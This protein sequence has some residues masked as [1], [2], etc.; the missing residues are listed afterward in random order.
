MKIA[1][2][3]LRAE[4]FFIDNS[5]LVLT[6]VGVMGTVTTALLAGK[7]AYTSGILIYETEIV[8]GELSGKRKFEMCWKLF[9][10]AVGTGAVTIAAIVGA[11]HIST[12]R[13]A[14]LAAA[15]SLSERAFTEYR[16]KIVETLGTKSERAVRDDI[17][18][19]RVKRTSEAAREIIVTGTEVICLDLMG[20]RYFNSSYAALKKA[21]NDL[22]FQL[23]HNGYATLSDFYASLGLKTTA[24]SDE[25]GWNSDTKL[26]LRIT[27][28]MTLDDRPCLAFEIQTHP[29]RD[30]YKFH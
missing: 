24:Y 19:D 7:A 11:N 5:P 1:T 15:Y 9:V 20:D 3:A 4:K 28:A 14:G 6:S 10:P 13:A 12:R 26:E 17:A 23:I 30:Y 16:D 25:L 8:P 18:Q 2:L 27:T 21:E 29:I 22:N